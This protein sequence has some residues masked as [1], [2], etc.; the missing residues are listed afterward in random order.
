MT[1]P[2][3]PSSIR[4]GWAGD[5]RSLSPTTAPRNSRNRTPVRCILRGHPARGPWTTRSGR[6]DDRPAGVDIRSLGVDPG[7]TIEA[8]HD[9][10]RSATCSG[11]VTRLTTTSCGLGLT[12]PTRRRIVR[13]SPDRPERPLEPRLSP[14]VSE[15]D[16]ARTA[17]STDDRHHRSAATVEAVRPGDDRWPRAPQDAPGRAERTDRGVEAAAVHAP[18]DRRVRRPTG[19]TRRTDPRRRRHDGPSRQ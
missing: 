9:S 3:A 2:T 10:L 12:V 1:R 4:E 8:D 13:G 17:G 19:Q 14:S 11:W 6:V 18:T 16:A 7:W 5:L 15:P